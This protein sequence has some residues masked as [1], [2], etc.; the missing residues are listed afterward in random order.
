MLLGSSSN[1]AGK[2]D[3]LKRTLQVSNLSPLLTVEQ[4]KQLF[5][6]CGTVVECTITDSKHFAYIEYSKPE[7]ATAALAL[8]NMDV[9]GRPLNVEMAKTLPQKSALLHSSLASSSLPMMMQQAVAMQ[10][11]QFQQALLMQQTLTAQQAANRAA[12]MK[13]ATELAAA[14]AAEISKKLK[15]DGL[16]GDEMQTKD[17]SR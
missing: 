11:M 10:Q 5:S 7:E 2:D 16:V 15:A 3:A 1:K 9:G 12:S 8:N 6:F 4:L 13:S 17:K 14:R